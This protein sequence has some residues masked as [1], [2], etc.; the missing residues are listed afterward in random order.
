MN[1]RFVRAID[2]VTAC[3]IVAPAQINAVIEMGGR[4]RVLGDDI[5]VRGAICRVARER[6]SVLSVVDV[7]AGYRHV[8]RSIDQ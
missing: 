5:V 4:N 7:V 2:D 6:D 3:G 8:L 1:S